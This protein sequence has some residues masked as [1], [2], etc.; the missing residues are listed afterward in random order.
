MGLL[1][2]HKWHK[3]KE[4]EDP[5]GY[6]FITWAC[7]CGRVEWETVTHQTGERLRY[8]AISQRGRYNVSEAPE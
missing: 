5:R 3:V 7:A 8:E 6:T 1:H 2:R 4:V